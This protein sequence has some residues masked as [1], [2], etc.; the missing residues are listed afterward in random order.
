MI[1]RRIRYKV[2]Y[3]PFPCQPIYFTNYKEA[4]KFIK[5]QLNTGNY[6]QSVNKVDWSGN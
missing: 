1:Y 2:Y 4:S 3:G 6:I 5:E